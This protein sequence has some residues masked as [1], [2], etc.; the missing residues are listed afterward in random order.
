[1]IHAKTFRHGGLRLA[2]DLPW[3]G[4]LPIGNAFLPVTALIPLKQHAG[5]AARCVVQKGD[6]VREGAMIGK[7]ERGDSAH[8]HAPIPGV[9]RD[10]RR[11]RTASD[12]PVE[13][14]EISLQGSFDRLGKRVERYIWSSMSRADMFQTLRDRGVVEMEEPG[15]PLGEMIASHERCS[16]LVLNCVES[17]PYIR[18]EGALMSA[19]GKEVLD[20]LAILQKLVSPG[21]TAAVFDVREEGERASIL[22]LLGKSETSVEACFAEPRYP[23]DM[24]NQLLAVLGSGRAGATPKDA[25]IVR[26]ST[27]LAIYEALVF[28]KPV[29]ERYVTVAGGAIKHPSVLKTRIGTSIGDLI[30]ECGGFVDAPEKL[31]VGGPLR[32]QPVFSLDS[33]VTK[34]TGGILALTREETNRRR[35]EACIRCGRCLEV[36]PER[37]APCELFRFIEKRRYGEAMANGLGDCTCCGACGYVCPSR[38]H[39]VEAFRFA[40][41]AMGAAK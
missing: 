10:I 39:L 8:I 25:F 21:H 17:E 33:P 24:P 38:I 28:A 5:P 3:T 4:G 41:K 40:N 29:M 30:E 22:E 36:C 34:L 12:G 2:Q 26:P 14:V 18:T 16:F 27:A 23:Q 35:T 13:A 31:V 20:G 11:I 7:G 19:R 15:R 37:L 32:G 1:M 9:V 6:F